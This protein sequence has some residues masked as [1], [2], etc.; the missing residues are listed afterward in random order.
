[1][2]IKLIRLL[3]IVLITINNIN[4]QIKPE[5]CTPWEAANYLV[6]NGVA[7]NS[8]KFTGDD[9]SLGKFT[10]PNYTSANFGFGEGIMLSTGSVLNSVGPKDVGQNEIRGQTDLRSKDLPVRGDE[11]CDRIVATLNDKDAH[12]GASLEIEFSTLGDQVEFEFIFASLEYP[13]F[14]KRNYFDV[15]CLLMK[16]P[17]I[18]M[19][20]NSN[21][22]Q[23]F[24]EEYK[25]YAKINNSPIAINTVNANTNSSYFID[26]R[27]SDLTYFDG[28]T[29]TIKVQI[30]VQCGKTYKLKIAIS[31]VADGRYDSYV[32][33]KRASLKT[34]VD[35]GNIEVPKGPF[36]SGK[37]YTLKIEGSTGLKYLW[38]NGETT[39]QI[40]V[41]PTQ[42]G[43]EYWVDVTDPVSGCTI[44]KKAYIGEVFESNNTKP[45]EKGMNN[46]YEYETMIR[47]GENICFDVTGYDNQSNE[48]ITMDWS[49]NINGAT[50]NGDLIERKK[51]KR[52]FCWTPTNNN[53]G[54]DSFYVFLRDNNPCSPGLDTV[55]FKITIICA[56]CEMDLFIENKD[57]TSN[58]IDKENLAGRKIW[59][60]EFADPTD[61]DGP[62]IIDASS[63]FVEFKA[64]KEIFFDI[65]VTIED[66]AT[67]DAFLAPVC[68]V[69][70]YCD[71]C[72]VNNNGKFTG[73]F[74]G[75]ITPNGDGYNDIW[76][77]VD[78]RNPRCAYNIF[79]F[80]LQIFT[81]A[82][83]K[84]YHQ[85]D[86]YSAQCCKYHSPRNERELNSNIASIFW[87]G[88]VN[89]RY[90]DATY[91]GILTVYDC[92]GTE[93]IIP[94]II[95]VFGSVNTSLIITDSNQIEL[96]N[97]DLN[98]PK[99]NCFVYPNPSNSFVNI[100]FEN[101]PTNVY[102]GTFEITDVHGKIVD[103]GIIKNEINTISLLKLDNAVYT[104]KI[105][106]DNQAYYKALIIQK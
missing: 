8:V 102:S 80:D 97:N 9:T 98:T 22:G 100:E 91:Y 19:E 24:T 30:P 93:S 15:F 69:K 68:T 25:N 55:K 62:V 54:F 2:I 16:G 81:N 88:K 89:G 85:K 26:G 23:F 96:K 73:T 78:Y 61:T 67:V 1:M 59:V 71:T 41:Y 29:T 48:K 95:T 18:P 38:N 76:Q 50:F 42:T 36:C 33:L 64:G 10:F 52:T 28:Y 84:I 106:L 40:T 104:I 90:I 105:L 49:N 99:T 11:D 4:A 27:P 56:N 65:G 51:P 79:G 17:G 83:N 74:G 94:L 86:D 37:P 82:G 53:I 101:F 35:V 75:F 13:E 31:D 7:I 43:Q 3:F 63:G 32:M 72:C 87:D 46:T 47:A 14:V 21:G 12:D 66:D 5:M 77:V 39:Q 103:S 20:T 92:D 44:R 70:E 45:Y 57:L 6:G 58:I 60:G 34:S